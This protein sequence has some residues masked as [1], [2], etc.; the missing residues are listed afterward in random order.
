MALQR[1]RDRMAKDLRFSLLLEVYGELLPEKQA[2]LARSYYDLDLSLSEIAENEG[3]TR[4][5]V[6]DAIKRAE[7]QMLLFEEKLGVIDKTERLKELYAA[8]RSSGD[9]SELGRF[10][11]DL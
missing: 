6:H 5:G 1:E 7:Q 9:C 11:E 8:A 3:I 10:I 4:Q 2:E